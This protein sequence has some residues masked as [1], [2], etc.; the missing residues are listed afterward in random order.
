MRIR[1]YCLRLFFLSALFSVLSL[2]T[3]AQWVQT[4]R[5][6]VYVNQNC[7]GYYESLPG[8]YASSG[9]NYPLLLFFEGIGEYGDGS[10]NSL[11]KLLNNGPPRYISQGKFPTSFTVN[12][13]VFKL[14]IITPQWKPKPN[15]AEPTADEVNSLIDFLYQKLSRRP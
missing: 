1:K 6:D 14:I 12:G 9:L 8:E 15:W 11:S 3:N 5:P 13:Q 4:P 7:N 10:L 2:T